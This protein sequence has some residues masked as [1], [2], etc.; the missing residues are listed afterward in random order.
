MK[1]E[2]TGYEK[3]KANLTRLDNVMRKQGLIRGGHWDYERVT[4]D[5][6]FEV[7]E[8]VYYLRIRGYATEGDVGSKKAKINLMTPLLGKYY[9]PHGVEYGENEVFPPALVNQCKTILGTIK[10]E[11][12]KIS[13]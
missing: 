4:Y 7:T 5:K 10:A 11:V 6:K 8:G 12:E 1:F 13:M 2:N 3:L 9:Y